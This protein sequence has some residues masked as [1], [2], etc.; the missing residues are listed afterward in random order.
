MSSSRI[1]AVSEKYCPDGSGGEL[2]TYS[3][4]RLL[5]RYGIHVRVIVR[6]GSQTREWSGIEVIGLIV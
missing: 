4:I 5:S 3:F 1:L 6:S 2:A